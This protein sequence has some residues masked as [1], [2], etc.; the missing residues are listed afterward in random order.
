[1]NQIRLDGAT[2]APDQERV[3]PEE[4]R[5]AQL[6]GRFQNVKNRAIALKGKVPC[7]RAAQDN[8]VDADGRVLFQFGQQYHL[9]GRRMPTRQGL[10]G[11]GNIGQPLNRKIRNPGNG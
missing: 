8:N 2:H 3:Q 6:P 7:D 1:M 5:E 4:R 9:P 10:H 11:F